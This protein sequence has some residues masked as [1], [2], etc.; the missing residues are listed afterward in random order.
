M[1]R[2]SPGIVA[3]SAALVALATCGFARAQDIHVVDVAL[4]AGTPIQ[5]HRLPSPSASLPIQRMVQDQYGFLWLSAADGLQRYD[6]YDFMKIPDGQSAN[7]VGFVI[8]QALTRDRAGRLWFGADDSLNRYDPATGSLTQYRSPNEACG[9]VAIAHDI[10]E[11]QDGV[12]WLATDD[13]VTA[14]DPVTSKTTCHRPRYTPAVGET[15]VIATAPV[16][17]GTLWITSSEGLYA[18]DRRSGKVTR[19]IKLETPSGRRFVCTGFPSRPF[20]DSSGTLWVGLSSGGDLASVD[21]ASGE[22][23]VYAFR[24]SGL[25]PNASSGVVSIQEDHDRALWLGT[26]KLG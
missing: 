20:Q 16:N 8:G 2:W 11:D 19:H 17:D 24:N 12:I 10:T 13:G 3:L 25:A 18:L 9:T 23:T 22:V 6:S 14:L 21:V 7:N 4:V 5:F 1:K 26:D 15:R